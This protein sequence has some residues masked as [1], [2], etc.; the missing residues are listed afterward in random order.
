MLAA[1]SVI[2]EEL[3]GVPVCGFAVFRTG[4]VRGNTILSP[5]PSRIRLRKN[6]LTER[7]P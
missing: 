3:P 6:S 7:C 4:E 5:E 1:T 2:A